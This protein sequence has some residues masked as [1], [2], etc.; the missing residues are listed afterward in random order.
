MEAVRPFSEVG[1]CRVSLP[2]CLRALRTFGRWNRP[3]CYVSG[4]R[5]G[6]RGVGLPCYPERYS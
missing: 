4:P 1:P 2:A 5:H 3:A 6:D